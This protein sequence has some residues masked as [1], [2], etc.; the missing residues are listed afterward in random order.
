MFHHKNQRNTKEDSNAENEKQKALRRMENE[1]QNDEVAPYQSY[2]NCKQITLSNPDRD[3]QNSL[4]KNTIRRPLSLERHESQRTDLCLCG[5]FT[6]QHCKR[7]L[8]PA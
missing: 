4:G 5:V 7:V 8:S 6:S 1:Q 2:F 3:W